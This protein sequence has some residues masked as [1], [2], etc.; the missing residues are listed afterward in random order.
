MIQK[1]LKLLDCTLRDGGYYNRWDFHPVLARN[2]FRDMASCNVDVVEAGFRFKTK[3]GYIGPF[4]YTPDRVLRDLARSGYGNSALIEHDDKL[5]AVMVN[6][7]EWQPKDIKGHFSRTDMATV[8][9][10]ATHKK[11]VRLAI[12]LAKA[13]RSVSDHYVFMF[14]LMQADLCPASD[15]S[16]ISKK[17]EDSGLFEVFYVADSLG[18][19]CSHRVKELIRQVKRNWSG[20]VGFH[21]HDNMGRALENSKSAQRAGARYIDGTIMGMGRGAGNARIEHL[22]EEYEYMDYTSHPL[23]ES[24]MPEFEKLHDEYKWGTNLAYYAAAKKVVHPTYVQHMQ[25]MGWSL[26][27]M[28]DTVNRL[29]ESELG[30]SFKLGSLSSALY[31]DGFAEGDYCPEDDLDGKE[32]LVVASGPSL[33]R[34]WDFLERLSIQ[35]NMFTIGLNYIDDIHD[36]TSLDM[37]ATCHV[38]HAQQWQS[39]PYAGLMCPSGIASFDESVRG[40]RRHY[41][42]E[43]EQDKFVPGETSCV[44]PYMLVFC[45]V[46]AA[47]IAGGAKKVYLAGF[48]GYDSGDRRQAEMIHSLDLIKKYLD[49]AVIDMPIVSLT[50]TNYPVEQMSLYSMLK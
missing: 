50:P 16:E 44:V 12:N 15:I 42:I 43:V 28:V 6:T 49:D 20:D 27:T 30:R 8:V 1:S 13:I 40:K 31:Q 26:G 14:N 10:F 18:S 41:G 37:F 32:V 4:G 39:R 19:M 3:Q 25:E 11:D 2:Y 29:S 33:G 24:V 35:S 5:L 23:I 22:L 17:V 36:K 34:H 21:A 38:A 7:A 9:R 48:D 45:Y 46:M 47:C